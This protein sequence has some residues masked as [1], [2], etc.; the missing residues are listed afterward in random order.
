MIDTLAVGVPGVKINA[1]VGL[2]RLVIA[3]MYSAR[4]LE[5]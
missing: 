5:G 3:A 1:F 4:H 2:A